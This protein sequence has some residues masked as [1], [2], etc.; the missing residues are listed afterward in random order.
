M[1]IAIYVVHKSGVV[2]ENG[3]I[4]KMSNTMS[5]TTPIEAGRLYVICLY[6]RVNLM[7]QSTF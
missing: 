6:L 1:H 5:S 2:E 4:L 7:A 3:Y